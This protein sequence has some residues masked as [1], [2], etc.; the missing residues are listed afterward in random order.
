MRSIYIITFI[1]TL[2]LLGACSEKKETRI[3][4]D[5]S[6]PIE[7]KVNKV[8]ENNNTPFITTSGKVQA[9]NSTDLSTRMMGYVTNINVK[10]G[11]K[12]N[13]GDLILSINNADLM[14]KRT[15]IEA[16]ITEA[17]ARLANAEKDYNRFNNL[18]EQNSASQK[19]LD[20]R[21]THYNMAKA[22]VDAAKGMKNEINAQFVYTSIRAPFSGVITNKFIDKGA[23]ANPGIPLISLEGKDDFEVITMVPENDIS[24]IKDG[25]AVDILIKSI[26]KTISGKVAEI[27]TSAR[28]TGG[29]YL[30]KI[31]L[32]ETNT[33][34]LSGMFATVQFPVENTEAGNNLVLIPR[35]AIISRGQLSGIYTISQSNTAI[36]RWLR[37]GRT[38]G[39][40]V[41]VLTGLSTNESYIISSEG[42]LYNGAKI[43]IQ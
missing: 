37:L 43:S 21:T 11:D 2:L 24:K 35:S 23:L 4:T 40:Q 5:N 3:K 19:E 10:V 18:F 34:I 32:D 6:P 41:E 20:D 28:K 16:S 12:V 29:Q 36:L 42:K 1:T 22:N 13:K 26:G 8:T 33:F 30:V 27:S 9:V 15:Q 17:E 25:I 31:D 14:A 7:V 38:L 39:N